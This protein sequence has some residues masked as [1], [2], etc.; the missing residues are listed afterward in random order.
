[1]K[2]VVDWICRV[3]VVAAVVWVGF[4]PMCSTVPTRESDPAYF[5]ARATVE[6]VCAQVRERYRVNL[7]L[8]EFD[9]SE[10]MIL[11]AKYRRA[12]GEDVLQEGGGVPALLM[13]LAEEYRARCGTVR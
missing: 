9:E 10:V 8:A 12:Q 3:A 4:M 13:K 2:N 5:A 7:T 1:M 11:A 6:K